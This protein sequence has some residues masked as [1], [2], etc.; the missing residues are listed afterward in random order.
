MLWHSANPALKDCLHLA[1][2]RGREEARI[3]YYNF[4]LLQSL[5][6]ERLLQPFCKSL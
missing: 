3:Y 2:K 4:L 6:L 5:F 1:A